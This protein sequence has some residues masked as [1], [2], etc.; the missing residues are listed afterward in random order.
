MPIMSRSIYRDR[1]RVGNVGME[2]EGSSVDEVEER[3]SARGPEEIGMEDTGPQAPGSGGFDVDAAL[4]RKGEGETVIE[5]SRPEKEQQDGD[6]DYVIVD[7]E[8]VTEDKTPNAS[9]TTT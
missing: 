8:E 1:T 4:G 5:T 9:A 2:S 6:G 7:A 3:V